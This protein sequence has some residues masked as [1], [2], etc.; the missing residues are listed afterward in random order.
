[1]IIYTT[2]QRR[3]LRYTASGNWQEEVLAASG[4][5]VDQSNFSAIAGADVQ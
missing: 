1:M 3:S 5:E 2:N 4:V